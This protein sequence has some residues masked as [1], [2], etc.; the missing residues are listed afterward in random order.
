MLQPLIR[1]CVL[2]GG[3]YRARAMLTCYPGGG[4]RYIRHVDNGNR[5][6]RKL[7]AILYLNPHWKEGDGKAKAHALSHEKIPC[8][9]HCFCVS[10]ENLKLRVWSLASV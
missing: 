7:T 5:N 10:I 6:G 3:V 4:A 2:C 1:V 8:L 9:Y